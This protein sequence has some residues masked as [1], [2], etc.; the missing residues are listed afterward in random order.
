MIAARSVSRCLRF[1]SLISVA[2]LIYSEKSQLEATMTSNEQ[3]IAQRH[4]RA[5]MSTSDQTSTT[6]KERGAPFSVEEVVNRVSRLVSFFTSYLWKKLASSWI[7]R[8]FKPH[9]DMS[10]AFDKIA[11]GSKLL[12]IAH[13]D[14]VTDFFN[15]HEFQ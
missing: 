14:E 10:H 3:T 4:D 1:L 8:F 15:S 7:M 2:L 6:L 9:I 12:I 13:A 5:L 11:A